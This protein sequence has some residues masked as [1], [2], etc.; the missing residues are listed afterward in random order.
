[1]T[2][3]AIS[4]TLRASPN[5]MGRRCRCRASDWRCIARVADMVINVACGP[6]ANKTQIL[7]YG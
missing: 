1:M 3:V 5:A 7:A 6:M 4:G 2:M